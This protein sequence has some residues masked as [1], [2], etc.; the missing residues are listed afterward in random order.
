MK[1]NS[2][3][4]KTALGRG[5]SE[6]ARTGFQRKPDAPKP[7]PAP[8][9]KTPRDTG[10]TKKTRDKLAERS[11]D[12]CEMCGHAEATDAHHRHGRLMGGTKRPWINALSNLIHACRPCHEMVTNTRG[13]R[14]EFERKG[15]LLREG[16]DP[17]KE[18]ALIFRPRDPD[19]PDAPDHADYYLLGDNGGAELAP[20]P[21]QVDI[22]PDDLTLPEPVREVGDVA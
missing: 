10:P 15:W 22:N 7:K 13:R 4:R 19:D 14:P 5:D 2:L 16:Q 12:V 6:L 1:R 11:G 21:V 8:K 3:P 9:T 20:W 18:S 17:R